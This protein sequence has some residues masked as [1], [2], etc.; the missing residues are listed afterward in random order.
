M[1][2][3]NLPKEK[4]T[5]KEKIIISSVSMQTAQLQYQT[6]DWQ[7]IISRPSSCLF[8][9]KGGGACKISLAYVWPWILMLFKKVSFCGWKKKPAKARYA[10]RSIPSFKIVFK[11]LLKY[12]MHTSLLLMWKNMNNFCHTSRKQIFFIVTVPTSVVLELYLINH[13]SWIK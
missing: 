12:F 11:W 8:T 7:E 1:L 13:V 6:S 2:R 4:E 3:Q 5:W 10:L 9:W